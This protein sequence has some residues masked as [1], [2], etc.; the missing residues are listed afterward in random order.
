MPLD[1]G[2]VQLRTVLM[3]P[4]T[5]YR[6]VTTFTPWARNVRADQGGDRA[7]ANGAWS[8]AEWAGQVAIPMRLF[9][10]G[11]SAADWLAKQQL[12]SAAFAPA[13]DDLELRFNVAGSEF[14]MYGRPRLMSP[15][16]RGASGAYVD[17]AFVAVDPLLYSGA[18]HTQQ[19]GLP[20]SAGG[21]TV[22]IT[23]P[24]TVSGTFIAGRISITNAGNASTGL[25][26]RVDGP[27]NQPSV[28]VVSGGV[29]Q[30]LQVALTLTAGQ[31]LDID[32]LARTVYL[33]GTASRR[34]QASGI[35]P[36]L[37]PGSVDVAFNAASY[38]A[39]ALLTVSWRDAWL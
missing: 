37:A 34:G 4:G 21:L 20:T 5:A 31:W 25:I 18:L 36:L 16:R 17:A 29:T 33:N 28:S 11:S 14:V 8:G 13:S 19:L 38:D 30:T 35:F 3:G 1:E 24:I 9:I 22:P 26:L 23:V 10:F 12:L 7:W 2:Q 27:C 32:T 39:A 15:V 6:F